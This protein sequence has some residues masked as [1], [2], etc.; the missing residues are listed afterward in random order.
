MRWSNLLER[1]DGAVL[2]LMALLLVVLFAFAAFAVDVSAAYAERREAQST[3]DSAVL[4]AALE[5]LSTNSPTGENLGAIVKA[6]VAT[7]WGEKAPSDAEWTACADPDRPADYAPIMDASVTPAV[8]VSD[9]ISLKQVNGEPALMRV[10]LPDYEMPTSF[11]A[12]IGFNEVAISATAT[13]ELRYSST[14]KILPFSLPTNPSSEECLATPPPGLLPGDDEP[15]DGPSQGNFGLIDSP[16]FGADDPHFTESQSCGSGMPNFNT[17]AP[18]NIALGLDH[19]ITTWPSPP[20]PP[21]TGVS[22][23]N[24]HPGADDCSNSNSGTVPFVLQTQTGNTQSA[25]GKALLQDGFIGD[26]PSPTSASV[27]GRLRQPSSPDA[28][29]SRLDFDTSSWDFDVDN[30]GLWEYLEQQANNT[31]PCDPDQF[32]PLVGREK[33]DQMLACLGSDPTMSSASFKEDLIYSPRF[34]VVPVLNYEDGNQ[35][36]TKWWGVLELRP[37]YLHT[38]WYD[39]TNGS[40][41]ECLFLPDDFEADPSFDV[42]NR[43]SYSLL[44]NPGEGDDPPCYINGS[45]CATPNT[46]RFQLMGISA[47][48]LDWD[49]LPPEAENQFGS[50]APLE[51]FLHGN[52]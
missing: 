18:H 45:N 20:A 16:W 23:P 36:G 13:A 10:R 40:D 52:E 8:P 1:E 33:T 46:N 24:N 34:A 32:T 25:S 50:S 21:S 15:C 22:Q 44:F 31:D 37:V 14:T 41:T 39:C 28:S 6:Y 9:C 30:V 29:G 19:V 43:D 11:A 38:T 12:I 27:P 26:D 7:N 47:L 5:Y 49:L 3:A 51:V 2:P 17:R 48:V 4:A 35:F 42:A